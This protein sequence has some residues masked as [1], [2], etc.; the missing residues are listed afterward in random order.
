MPPAARRTDMHVCP[1]HG[2]GPIVMPCVPNV[3]T[4]FLPQ[5]VLGDLCICLGMPIDPIVQASRTVIVGGRPAARIGDK[6]GHGGVIVT[7]CPTVI[8]GG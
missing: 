4:G 1:I 3:L 8:I 6:T 7:G 2:G 5:A